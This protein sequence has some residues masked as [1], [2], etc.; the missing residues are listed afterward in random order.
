MVGSGAGMPRF[1]VFGRYVLDVRREEGR[2]VAYRVGE[3]TRRRVNLPVPSDLDDGDL[4]RYLEDLLHESSS[5]D[6]S[7]RRLP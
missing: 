6:T 2:W 7:L 1:D 4:D 3:G 5:P